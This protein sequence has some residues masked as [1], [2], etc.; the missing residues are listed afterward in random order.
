MSEREP[1]DDRREQMLRA[2]VEVIGE[3]GFADTRIADVGKRV[4]ASSALV[5]YYF[6]TKDHLLTEA[7]RYSEDLFYAEVAARLAQIAA[8]KDKLADLVRYSCSDQRG[9]PGGSWTLWLDLWAQAIR[10]PDVARDR[11]Q[12]DGRWRDQIVDIVKH[13]Q[14]SGE[15]VEIDAQRFAVMFIALLDGLVVQLV[16]GDSQITEELAIDICL[17]V[18][19]RELGFELATVHR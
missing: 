6:G 2:A 19:A 11:E 15:F 10:H 9:G 16:L 18:A 14:E 12:L 3:R 13:G 4:G 5:I 17:T 1:V 7:L 8:A